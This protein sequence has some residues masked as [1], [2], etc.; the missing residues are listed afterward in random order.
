MVTSGTVAVTTIDTATLLEHAFRR[1]KVAPSK[2]T[3]E[4]VELAKQNLYLLLLGLAGRGLNLWCVESALVGL[5]ENQAVYVSPA[6]TIDILNVVHCDP[7]LETVT[8]SSITDGGKAQITATMIVRVGFQPTVDFT[9]AL[10]V[11]SSTDDVSYTT[12]KSIGSASYTAG[13]WYW[14]DLPIGTSATYFKVLG[15]GLTLTSIRL[16]SSIRD[17]PVN[18]WN[19]DTYAVINNKRQLG[20]PAVNYYLEKK[21]TPQITL[22]PVPN[23]DEN[24]LM[25]FV[26]RQVQDVGTLTQQLELPQRWIEAIIWQLS[27]RLAY[28]LKEV[29]VEIVNLVKPIA[30]ETYEIAEMAESDGASIRLAPNI[31]GYTA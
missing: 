10:T 17:L 29:P 1:V 25:L 30:D 14:V 12:L 20:S 26:H 22:W 8:F 16:A 11:S 13:L 15:T 7:Q 2:Q 4:S 19:R 28:E 3:A 6:G 21:L 23:D 9:G 5:V 24:H 31:S 18:Q 27:L